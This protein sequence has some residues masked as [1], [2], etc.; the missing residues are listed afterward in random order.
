MIQLVQQDKAELARP[1]VRQRHFKDRARVF[2]RSRNTNKDGVVVIQNKFDEFALRIQRG[3]ARHGHVG[4][5]KRDAAV[6]NTVRMVLNERVERSRETVNAAIV[7]VSTPLDIEVAGRS[8]FVVVLSTALAVRHDIVARLAVVIAIGQRSRQAV[9]VNGDGGDKTDVIEI[10]AELVG[11]AAALEGN[12]VGACLRCDKNG[13][14]L[15]A[16]SLR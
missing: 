12:G 9:F 4:I 3:Y 15:P 7:V 5:R 1:F 8:C 13:N 10:G 2:S 16:I 14:V 6:A 11:L